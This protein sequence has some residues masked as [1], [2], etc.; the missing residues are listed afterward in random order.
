[1]I[2]SVEPVMFPGLMTQFPEGNP[3]STMLPVGTEQVGCIMV[4]TEGGTGRLIKLFIGQVNTP[5]PLEP[6]KILFRLSSKILYNSLLE[7]YY[8]M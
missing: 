8:S 2:L 4:S 6:A 7:Q 3:P 1:M 5:I